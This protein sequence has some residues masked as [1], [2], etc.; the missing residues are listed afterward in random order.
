[1]IPIIIFARLVIIIVTIA[2]VVVLYISCIKQK[3][4]RF[5]I[6]LDTNDNDGFMKLMNV[7]KQLKPEGATYDD[8]G[9]VITIEVIMR[10]SYVN[11]FRD[12]LAQIKTLEFLESR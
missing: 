10:Q 5:R 2:I 4:V 7:F 8:N 6:S 3:E 9:D 1:M 11:T 12:A